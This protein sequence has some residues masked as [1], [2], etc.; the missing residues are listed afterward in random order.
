MAKTVKFYNEINSETGKRKRPWATVKHNF[1]RVP[2]QSYLPRFRHYLEKYGI[3]KQKLDKIDDY[4]FDMFERAQEK[5]L[6]VH[7]I[8]LCRWALKQAVDQSLYNFVASKH[9]LGQ[10]NKG[11]SF[12]LI[13][14]NLESKLSSLKRD[15]HGKRDFSSFRLVG[16]AHSSF[17]PR[18]FEIEPTEFVCFR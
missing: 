7:D 2:H 16:F 11:E 5:A 4:V 1:Q 3:K 6:L 9:C 15:K 8:D 10:D 18:F 13:S 12:V 17:A 14:K